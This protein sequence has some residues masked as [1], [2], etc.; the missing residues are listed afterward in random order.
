MTKTTSPSFQVEVFDRLVYF[1][2]RGIWTLSAD[3]QWLTRMSEVMNN[4]RG[5][6]WYVL[7]D[8]RG[9]VLPPEVASSSLRA[10]HSIDRRN[11]QA[12][13]WWVNKE[14]NISQLDGFRKMLPV[15]VTVVT[16]KSE[17][18][19]W[20]TSQPTSIPDFLQK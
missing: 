18:L 3:L 12:E 2:V 19:D 8:M 6:P 10:K 5:A 1:Q 20:L 16:E 15:D 17:M 4:M 7:A 14:D 9:W 11:E 13:C